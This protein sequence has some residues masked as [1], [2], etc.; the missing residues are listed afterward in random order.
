VEEGE[1]D[2]TEDRRGAEGKNSP[3]CVAEQATVSDLAQRYEV[4]PNQIYA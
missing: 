3:R 4:D 1:E 2:E